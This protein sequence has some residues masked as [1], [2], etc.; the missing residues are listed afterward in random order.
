MCGVPVC[1]A[2]AVY[3]ETVGPPYNTRHGWSVK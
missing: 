3:G 2:E 1:S